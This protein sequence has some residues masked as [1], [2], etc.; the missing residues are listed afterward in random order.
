[1]S[2]A[3]T[4]D[5]LQ[6]NVKNSQLCTPMETTPFRDASLLFGFAYISEC[7]RLGVVGGG[8]AAMRNGMVTNAAAMPLRHQC[9]SWELECCPGADAY[10]GDQLPS[11]LCPQCFQDVPSKGSFRTHHK[12]PARIA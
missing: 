1:M 6:A 7:C 12:R 3:L 8:W 2:K 10:V 4:F 11:S 5:Q 9:A